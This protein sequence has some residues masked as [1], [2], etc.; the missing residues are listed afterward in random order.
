MAV[1]LLL[2]SNYA[3]YSYLDN[4][5]DDLKIENLNKS[6]AI[7][8]HREYLWYSDFHNVKQITSSIFWEDEIS[9]DE[10]FMSTSF[11]NIESLT[12]LDNNLD[13]WMRKD[14]Y[15]RLLKL[16]KHSDFQQIN[17]FVE[18]L[19]SLWLQNITS[20]KLINFLSKKRFND[21]RFSN[22]EGLLKI[23]KWGV[24]LDDL[25]LL[26][27]NIDLDNNLYNIEQIDNYLDWWL[28]VSNVVKFLELQ[29]NWNLSFQNLYEILNSI[30]VYFNIKLSM[31]LISL[32]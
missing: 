27:D 26:E 12:D 7:K 16:N 23:F 1:W 14:D 22:Y 19:G 3:T 18:K 30:Q 24:S 4:K 21:I 15:L 9:V 11:A 25:F 31:E 10:S 6:D 2:W 17:W 29:N 8:D 28:E 5:V 13:W 32:N 20:S